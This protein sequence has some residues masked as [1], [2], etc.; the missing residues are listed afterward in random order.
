MI[1]ARKKVLGNDR[2]EIHPHN[3]PIGFPNK[4]LKVYS[5]R[6]VFEKLGFLETNIILIEMM[7]HF[8]DHMYDMFVLSPTRLGKVEVRL[9][10]YHFLTNQLDEKKIISTIDIE[11]PE[12][13]WFKIDDHHNNY[14]G[15][16]L[17][18]D[19]Y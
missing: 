11:I 2:S 6:R 10:G 17:F 7:K 3:L 1:L 5:T 14:V 19:E 9:S 12:R 18:P 8:Q 16:L 15:T 13:I 4:A